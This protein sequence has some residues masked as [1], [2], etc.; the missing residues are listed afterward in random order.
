[1]WTP[2]PNLRALP[3]AQI[4]RTSVVSRIGWPLRVPHLKSKSWKLKIN[5]SQ[6]VSRLLGSAKDHLKDGS[7]QFKTALGNCKNSFFRFSGQLRT[8]TDSPGHFDGQLRTASESYRDSQGQLG[9]PLKTPWVRCGVGLDS[10]W[11]QVNFKLP[12]FS[13]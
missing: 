3:I 5:P 4:F 1:M 8:A 11:L 10:V 12:A 13:Q 9:T 6:R 7:G 2:L